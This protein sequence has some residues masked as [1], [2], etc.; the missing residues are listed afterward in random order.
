MARKISNDD[1][2][3]VK[4]KLRSRKPESPLESKMLLSSGSTLVNLAATGRTGGCFVK[5]CYHFFVGDSGSGKTWLC[6]T[7]L[8][9]A[10]LSKKFAGYRL[11]YDASENGALMDMRRYFGDSMVERLEPPRVDDNGEPWY[12]ETVEDMY[13]NLDDAIADGRPF[14]YVEDSMDM[15]ETRDNLKKQLDQKKARRSIKP[16]EV[17][18]S[19]GDGKAKYNSTHLRGVV[20]KLKRTG[21]ILVIIS[22]TRDKIGQMATRGSNKTR[23][24]GHALTFYATS[25]F[26]T[27]KGLPITKTVRNKKRQIGTEMIVKIKKNRTSGRARSV[28]VPIYY[29]HG[30][31]DVGSC[32][33][34]LLDEDHWKKG[35]KGIKC[36]EWDV[37]MK[38]DE[39]IT[40]I[41]SENMEDELRAIV[42]EV[43]K[44]I[45]TQCA[46]RRKSRYGK[47]DE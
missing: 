24:G 39:L 10:A 41:E 21:S 6:L 36:P 9:E 46:L 7:L 34:Y 42:A 20:N 43:W 19:Y 26:W 3:D 33:D 35:P 47:L 27:S 44:D 25:E 5:G 13:D 37:V 32:I 23:A 15:L 28:V 16:K 12:S 1:V 40:Y 8:A 14:I 2:E 11:I 22:Q 17:P 29:S 38:R 30:V 18:G 4:K 31:D 45:E